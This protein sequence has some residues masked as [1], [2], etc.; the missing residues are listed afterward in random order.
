V[1]TY[2]GRTS[3]AATDGMQPYE[4]WYIEKLLEFFSPNV[5]DR[6]AKYGWEVPNWDYITGERLVIC[7]DPD[8]CVQMVKEFEEIGV[9]KIMAQ[10]QVGG[11]PHGQ[12]MEAMEL[13]AKEVMPHCR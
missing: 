13:F 3:Q 6:K 8:E 11:M 4:L 9:T 1:P 10:F 12:V 5:A 2:V 7:G